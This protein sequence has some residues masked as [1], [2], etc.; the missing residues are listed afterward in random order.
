MA[1]IPADLYLFSSFPPCFAF[2]HQAIIMKIC[3]KDSYELLCSFD[4]VLKHIYFLGFKEIGGFS[5]LYPKYM[6]ATTAFRDINSSCGLPREDAFHILR[7]PVKSDIPWLGTVLHILF[8]CL[9]YF[10]CDQVDYT[11]RNFYIV[12]RII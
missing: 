4:L 8:G 12:L 11:Y 10:C 7:H 9:W 6:N 3:Y 5:N 2:S 1:S